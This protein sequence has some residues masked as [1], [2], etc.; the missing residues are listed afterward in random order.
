MRQPPPDVLMHPL[1]GYLRG[2]CYL[3]AGEKCGATPPMKCGAIPPIRRE[4][5]DDRGNLITSFTPGSKGICRWWKAL[6][7]HDHPEPEFELPPEEEE[8]TDA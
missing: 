7:F 6:P 3:P 8:K 5:M 2:N 4:W 1:C